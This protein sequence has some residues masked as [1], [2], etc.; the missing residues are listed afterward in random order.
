EGVDLH[1]TEPWVLTG[2]SNGQAHIYHAEAGDLLK[3]FEVAN[4]PACC[5][6]FIARD[7]RLVAG[8]DDFQ[9]RVFNRKPHPCRSHK[10]RSASRLHT[11]SSGS[12]DVKRGANRK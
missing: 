1:P 5:I 11:L 12:S 4:V 3:T 9:L 7:H 2:L 10:F 8:S 6:N